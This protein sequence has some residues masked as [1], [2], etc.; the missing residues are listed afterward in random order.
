MSLRDRFYPKGLK[1]PRVVNPP[2]PKSS[3]VITHTGGLHLKVPSL[4]V[5][6]KQKLTVIISL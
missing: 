4:K 2:P 3:S 1:Q 6:T 5:S